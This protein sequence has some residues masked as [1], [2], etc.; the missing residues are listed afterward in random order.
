MTAPIKALVDA[1]LAV[2]VEYFGFQ[3]WAD[4][5]IAAEIAASPNLARDPYPG[6]MLERARRAAVEAL[7]KPEPEEEN[8]P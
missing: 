3:A 8:T 2:V 1:A 5:D 6:L 7:E 4:E